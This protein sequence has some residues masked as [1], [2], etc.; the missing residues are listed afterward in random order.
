M[1]VPYDRTAAARNHNF[2]YVSHSQTK[3]TPYLFNTCFKEGE[4]YV[5]ETPGQFSIITRQKKLGQEAQPIVLRFMADV[6][7]E[8]VSTQ[9][10]EL[11]TD[12]IC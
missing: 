5:N 6:G 10:A 4:V 2:L 1:T 7:P 9:C 8:T 11:H 12:D 3:Q